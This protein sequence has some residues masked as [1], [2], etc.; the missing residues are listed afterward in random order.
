MTKEV[1]GI[2]LTTFEEPIRE[3]LQHYENVSGTLEFNLDAAP[4]LELTPDK[5]N[6]ARS[7]TVVKH[8]GETMGTLYVIAFAPKDGTGDEKTYS[9]N[10]ILGKPKWLPLEP[11]AMPRSKAGIHSEI[12]LP[13][14]SQ[15][16][17]IKTDEPTLF[18]GNLSLIGIDQRWHLRL[19]GELGQGPTLF[20]NA[21]EF[22]RP[23][24]EPVIR[25]TA[26][27][28]ETLDH[29]IGDPHAVYNDHPQVVQVAGFLAVTDEMAPKHG[30][31]AEELGARQPLWLG[32]FDAPT[33]MT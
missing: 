16:A 10:Q 26:G 30:S 28:N 11:K 31:L 6:S 25:L 1:A 23:A 22:A 5:P 9:V 12:H 3:A 33:P 20:T 18:A 21:L 19:I 29:R 8:L 32:V 2:D 24:L 4:K 15:F 17:E 13:L 27:T 7:A 14:A